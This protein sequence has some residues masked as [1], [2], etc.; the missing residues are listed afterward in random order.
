MVFHEQVMLMYVHNTLIVSPPVYRDCDTSVFSRIY[1][2]QKYIKVICKKIIHQPG[3]MASL[4]KFFYTEFFPVIRYQSSIRLVVKN[5]LTDVPSV[6]SKQY[7]KHSRH[8]STVPIVLSSGSKVQGKKHVEHN[9]C[10]V[11]CTFHVLE[12]CSHL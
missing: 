7:T 1:P 10:Y 3:C 9:S 8:I 2:D 11:W 6:T 4:H 5:V 12:C